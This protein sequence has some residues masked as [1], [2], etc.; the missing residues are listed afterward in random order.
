MRKISLN[1]SEIFIPDIINGLTS[2]VK[3]VKS[4]YHKVKPDIVA[5]QASEEELEGLKKVIEGEECEYF[6]SNYEEIYARRLANFGDVKV[7]P[8]CYETALKLCIEHETPIVPIDMDDMLYADIFCENISG[9]DLFRHS[10]RVKKLRKKRFK[11]QTAKEF[12]VEWDNEINKLK[13]FRNLELKREEYMASEILRMAKEHN[14]VLCIL[15]MQRAEGVYQKVLKER[16][17]KEAD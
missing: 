17:E 5:M 16:K 15:E 9:W 6:L 2:E 8:P 1:Q 7:P 10:I 11:A 4:A 13:G 14:R 12:V 3:K